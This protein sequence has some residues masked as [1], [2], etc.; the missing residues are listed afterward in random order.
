MTYDQV[1]ERKRKAES[2]ARNVLEDDQR[3]DEIADEP[4]EDYAERRHF[5]IVD[6]PTRRI[7]AM[8]NNGPSKQDLMDQIADLQD[9]NNMLQS[10]LDAISDI[11]DGGGDDNSDGGGDQD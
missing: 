9:E 11:L 6:D 2:F 5:D 4:V 1:A 7:A 8:S 3:A 10:Q